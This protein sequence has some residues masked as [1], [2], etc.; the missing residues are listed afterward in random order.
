MSAKLL[1]DFG[2]DER[3]FLFGF[4]WSKKTYKNLS[5]IYPVSI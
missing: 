1:K 2:N 5:K 4:N 3:S